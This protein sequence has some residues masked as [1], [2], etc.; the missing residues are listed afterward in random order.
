[1]QNSHFFSKYTTVH[2]ELRRPTEST[3]RLRHHRNGIGG[4]EVLSQNKDKNLLHFQSQTEKEFD[5]LAAHFV[6]DTSAYSNKDHHPVYKGNQLIS[7]QS[8]IV[9]E[10]NHLNSEP[11]QNCNK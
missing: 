8:I 7:Q 1:M 2:Q 3:V 9:V 10:I 4:V 6:G 11:Q 5:V